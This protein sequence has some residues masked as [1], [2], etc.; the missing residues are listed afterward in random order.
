[1]DFKTAVT[2]GLLK[3]K[4][5]S[6]EILIVTGIVG[7]VGAGVMACKATL[8]VHEVLDEHKE[9]MDKIH[10]VAA[11]NREDYTPKDVK[12]DTTIRYIQTA[13]GLLKIYG[14][15]IV[16][17]I[18]SIAAILV[19][20]NILQKRCAALAAAYAA[21]DTAFRAYR[22]RVVDKYGEEEDRKLYS[23]ADTIEVVEMDEKGKTKKQKVEVSPKND[24][25]KYFA[26]GN[27]YW[28]DDDQFVQSFFA[29]RI[30][31][32]NKLLRK[33]GFMTLNEVYRKLG[34]QE[35]QAGLVV[36]WVY[37]PDNERGDN[38]IQIYPHKTQIPNDKGDL[39]DAYELDFNVDGNIYDY[40]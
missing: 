3:C 6:P 35:T 16:L 18:A 11:E 39:V 19:G 30:N 5:H 15:A 8:K 26:P 7:L 40:I 2:K 28:E 20:N 1:M 29:M 31:E 9:D 27:P 24:Y 13:K 4:K 25:I 38:Y 12:K 17:A 22:G 36:G 23:G 33:K 14:P 10:E 32:V 21:S 37:R 34:L